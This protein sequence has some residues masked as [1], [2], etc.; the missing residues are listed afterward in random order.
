MPFSSLAKPSD[1]E[2]SY[3]AGFF[4]ANG[5]MH[6]RDGKAP[7][8]TMVFRRKRAEAIHKL[9]SFYRGSLYTL[10]QG[11]VGLNLSTRA[12]M[13]FLTDVAPFCRARSAEIDLVLRRFSTKMTPYETDQ[14][15]DAIKEAQARDWGS[16]PP[17]TVEVVAAPTELDKAYCAGLLDGSCNVLCVSRLPYRNAC[18]ARVTMRHPQ[19]DGVLTVQRFYGGT[20]YAGREGRYSYMVFR[21]RQVTRLLEELSPY[22]LDRKQDAE[23]VLARIGASSGRFLTGPASAVAGTP[24]SEVQP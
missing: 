21:R 23:R 12:S 22:L 3:F 16:I 17:G 4:D 24:S 11:V 15:S 6:V 5:Q 20:T 1:L 8:L 18:D 19:P 2:A 10:K 14:L 9:A 7:S 13:V